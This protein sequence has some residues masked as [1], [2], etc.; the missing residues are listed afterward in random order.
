MTEANPTAALLI[1]GNEILSGRTQ[2]KNLN[3]IAKELNAIGVRF[4]EV[5]VV[6]DIPE[7]II[8]AVNA[9]RESYTYVFT[10]GGIGP[11]HDDITTECIAS[12]FGVDVV[13]DAE[14][15]S[16]MKVY[17]DKRQDELTPARRRMACVPQ[18]AELID[19]PIS[20]APGYRIGNVFVMAGIPNIM[21]AMF[22]SIKPHLASGKVM[23][24]IEVSA[25]V[26]ES[27]IAEGLRNLQG[28]YQQ[29]EIGSYPFKRDG[30]YGVSIVVRTLDEQLLPTVEEEVKQLLAQYGNIIE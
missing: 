24:S 17:Y 23:Y 21:Q 2:D 18:G 10:T 6:P 16:R 30:Y 22:E 14:A 3:Y 28:K 9:L 25:T 29:T 20:I 15:I 19:N 11:T 27:I 7:N 13:E 26:A 12:A 4:M 5:R 8:T 1:I